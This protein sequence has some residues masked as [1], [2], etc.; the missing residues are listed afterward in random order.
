M[1]EITFSESVGGALKEA[2]GYLDELSKSDIV[3][4]GVSA[5]IG[6][7][8]EPMFGEYRYTLISKMLYQ[9]QWGDD[10]EAKAE[11]RSLGRYY[12]REYTRLKTA[13]KKGEPVRLWVSELPYLKCG[14]LWLSG[15]LE[16]YNAEVYTV[17]LQQYDRQNAARAEKTLVVHS[18]WGECEPRDFIN[19]LPLSRRLTALELRANAMK[20]DALVRENSPLRAVISGNVVSVPVNFYDF[21]IWRY[22]KDKPV[23]EAFL[24]G[25][26]LGDNRIGLP[27]WWMAYRIEHYI[28]RKSIIVIDDNERK[29]ARVLRRAK[30]R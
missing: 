26:I 3:C 18:G 21:L 20:W 15:L 16:R 14:L 4:L 1:V 6:D 11:I 8:T 12:A 9:W 17:E 24:I 30:R 5:E 7:I 19:A 13:L 25:K 28:R 29:Y 2:R 10:P 23:K 22:L 27:D